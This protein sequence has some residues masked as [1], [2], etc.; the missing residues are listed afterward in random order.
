MN[1]LCDGGKLGF[2]PSARM[3]CTFVLCHPER[4]LLREGPMQS[5]GAINPILRKERE[6]WDTLWYG[7]TRP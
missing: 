3:H 5:G 6:G 1:E 2:G 4:V 7:H